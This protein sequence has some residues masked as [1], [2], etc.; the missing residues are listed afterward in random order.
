[1]IFGTSTQVQGY[2]FVKNS[3]NLWKKLP[4]LI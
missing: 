1:M 4:F 2:F 3:R